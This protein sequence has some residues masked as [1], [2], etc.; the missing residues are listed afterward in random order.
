[1]GER[2]RTVE[3]APPAWC[4]LLF[5]TGA[6][7]F[8]TAGFANPTLTVLAMAIRLADHLLGAGPV[9]SLPLP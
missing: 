3:A 9:S 4:T 6:S 1:M 8:P 5:V 7:V 2:D